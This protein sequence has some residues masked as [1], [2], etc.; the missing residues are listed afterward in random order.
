MFNVA[1][2]KAFHALTSQPMPS[3][4]PLKA[5]GAHVPPRLFATQAT[6][7]EQTTVDQEAPQKAQF[8]AL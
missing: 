8:S 2:G 6:I 3:P 4:L 5:V 1:T 7:D